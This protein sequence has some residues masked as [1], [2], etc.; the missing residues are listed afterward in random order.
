MQEPSTEADHEQLLADAIDE[1]TQL[2]NEGHSPRVEEFVT[3]YADCSESLEPILRSLAA[4]RENDADHIYNST[5]LLASPFTTLGDYRL[6]REVGRG[7][8]GIVYEAE[9]VGLRRLVAV[10]V[11]PLAGLMDERQLERFKNETRAAAMLKHPNIVSVYSVGCE[12]GVHYYAM[13]LVLGHSLSEVIATL[14]DTLHSSPS[15]RGTGQTNQQRETSPSAQVGADPDEP[16][17]SIQ[18]ADTQGSLSSGGLRG[19]PDRKHSAGNVPKETVSLTALSTEFSNNR[20]T[21][22][23]SV[24]RLGI[25]TAR[26]LHYAHGEGVI[27]R[28]IKPSNNGCVCCFVDAGCSPGCTSLLP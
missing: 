19:T 11:L 10:K 6:L 18:E 3:R 9:Q 4:L 16:Q 5:R 24:A 26:A 13:E 17:Q 8:M 1:F 12:R 2:L 23:R 25:Q 7:G 21:Y 15:V 28:D 27:H 20:K 22:Y 14:S